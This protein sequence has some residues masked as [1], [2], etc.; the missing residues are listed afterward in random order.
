MLAIDDLISPVLFTLKLPMQY[1]FL[2]HTG[3][4]GLV[5]ERSP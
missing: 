5:D 2:R 4:R 1:F 3:P